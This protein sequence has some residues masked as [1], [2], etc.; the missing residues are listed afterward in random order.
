MGAPTLRHIEQYVYL[1]GLSHDSALIAW[2]AFEF[3]VEGHPNTGD[4]EL[5]TDRKLHDADATRPGSIG[6]R[7]KAYGPQAKVY[8]FEANGEPG[9][10]RYCVNQNYI[11]VRDLKP[12]TEYRYRVVV[13]DVTG[14]EIDWGAPPLRDW[15]VLKGSQG[16][17]GLWPSPERPYENRFRTFPAPTADVSKVCFAVIGDFGKGIRKPSEQRH[18]AEALETAVRERDVRFILTTGDNVYRGGGNDDEWFYTYF[19]PYR[20][21]INRVP[22]FP[23]FGNH[24]EVETEGE[25]DRDQ[26]YDNL[27]VLPH[28]TVMRDPGD[29]SL[30]PGLFYRFR[31]GADIEFVCVDTSKGAVDGRYFRSKKNRAF[32]EKAF[33][34]SNPPRWRIPFWHHPPYSAGP[35]HLGKES[36]REELVDKYLQPTVKVA[37]T[38][39]EHNFQYSFDG[40][41]HHFLTGGGGGF[42]ENEPR[43]DRLA[44]E[45][46]QVWGGNTEGH[47]LICEIDGPKI[48]IDPVGRLKDRALRTIDVTRVKSGD[49]PPFIVNAG[50]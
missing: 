14:H 2:G 47:F 3:E 39:H 31:F 6:V 32:L 26:L 8:V 20:H 7:A 49:G 19:Q 9:S 5:T 13:E 48:T 21:V 43:K 40:R 16:K 18:I 10:P 50:D 33:A 24:D 30:D 4:W 35:T 44:A 45:K 41:I 25:D 37:F 38:G 12:D 46:T 23:S 42:R 1:P 29:A 17:L 22:V 15:N 28:L 11:W 34:V 27:Y 36:I